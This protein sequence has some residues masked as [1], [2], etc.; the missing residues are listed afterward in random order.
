[1]KRTLAIS[2]LVLLTTT[3]AWAQCQ[4]FVTNLATPD[5]AYGIAVQG[6]YAYVAVAAQGVVIID[7]Q[8]PAA[9]AQVGHYDAP[10]ISEG[11]A[12][13]GGYAYLAAGTSGLR[14]IDVSNPTTPDEVGFYNTSGSAKDVAVQGDHAYVADN[15]NGLV[16]INVADPT[17]PTF[18]GGVDTPEFAVRI[19]VQGDYAYIADTAGGL[20]VIDILSPFNPVEV[21]DLPTP[22]WAYDVQVYGDLALVAANDRGVRVV[23]VS[24]PFS[25]GEIGFF[26]DG[27]AATQGVAFD[28]RYIYMAER[29]YGFQVADA[30]DLTTPVDVGTV[31]TDEIAY[32]VALS[33]NG[34]YAFVTD[35]EGGLNVFDLATCVLI[36]ADD[37]ELGNLS[38]WSSVVP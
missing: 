34:L 2:A 36:F 8:N 14:V 7:V 18:V 20:R 4:S 35:R 29:Q 32:N 24:N 11:I 30:A 33:E 22:G 6:R 15:Q 31:D 3:G 28:G 5:W 1:M 17:N 26:F 38:R 9:P 37:F 19:D 25:P 10:S 12:V 16:V 27:Q 13:S 23:D 21:G